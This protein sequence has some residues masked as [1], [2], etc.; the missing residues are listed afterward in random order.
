MT[1]STLRLFSM[2]INTLR[3]PLI[4]TITIVPPSVRPQSP[5]SASLGVLDLCIF[6]RFRVLFWVRNVG[7]WFNPCLSE[8]DP[9]TRASRARE[10]PDFAIIGGQSPPPN[11]NKQPNL[12]RENGGGGAPGVIFPLNTHPP[13]RFCPEISRMHS[14]QAG[15]NPARLH[16]GYTKTTHIHSQWWAAKPFWCE[17]SI[18][19]VKLG[20]GDF[21]KSAISSTES[22]TPLETSTNFG[23]SLRK[24]GENRPNFKDL[25]PKENGGFRRFEC[26]LGTFGTG[27]VAFLLLDSLTHDGL[28]IAKWRWICTWEYTRWCCFRLWTP[29]N[30][31]MQIHTELSARCWVCEVIFWTFYARE[32]NVDVTF[33]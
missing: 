21:A 32:K 24:P 2:F 8:G 31:E 13:P 14:L 6:R 30:D 15:T 17:P 22:R 5:T 9:R 11:N 26:D 29:T 20:G 3:Y 33:T 25:S 1:Y 7:A 10:S 18:L 23:G 16:C 4:P 12:N 19:K 27:V 28:S